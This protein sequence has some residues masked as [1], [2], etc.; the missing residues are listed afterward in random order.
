MFRRSLVLFFAAAFLA[1]SFSSVALS[2]EVES[3]PDVAIFFAES[4][5]IPA[6]ELDIR[7]ITAIETAAK[8][9]SVT[10]LTSQ[11]VLA[12]INANKEKAPV[13]TAPSDKEIARIVTAKY[14]KCKLI[15]RGEILK[16]EFT[17]SP[18]INT[19]PL[20]PVVNYT[21]TISLRRTIYDIKAGK[22]LFN[23]ETSPSG[24]AAIP[25]KHEDTPDFPKTVEL[26]LTKSVITNAGTSIVK[27]VKEFLHIPLRLL[28]ESVDNNDIIAN[29]VE[30]EQTKVGATLFVFET[31]IIKTPDDLGEVE[32]IVKRG[33]AVVHKIEDKRVFLKLIEGIAKRGY[34]ISDDE[35]LDL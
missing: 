22:L 24:T 32:S 7:L 3:A 6:P 11:D 2:E 23:Q 19:D 26:G 31:V 16:Y 33:K 25:Q 13:E 5:P 20:M 35:D 10:F 1:I 17:K 9:A 28:I 29:F 18:V 8:E 12:L 30:G 34:F 4:S 15:V 14:P 27:L 21:V